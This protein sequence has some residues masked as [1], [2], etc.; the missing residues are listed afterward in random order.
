MNLFRT[1]FYALCFIVPA[2]LLTLVPLPFGEDL[3]DWMARFSIVLAMLSGMFV[4]ARRVADKPW[5]EGSGVALGLTLFGT[6]TFMT[7]LLHRSAVVIAEKML[8][9]DSV[10]AGVF[11]SVIAFIF[12]IIIR[13]AVHAC[14]HGRTSIKVGLMLELRESRKTIVPFVLSL[15][16]A[17]LPSLYYFLQNFGVHVSFAIAQLVAWVTLLFAW[18]YFSP[19]LQEVASYEL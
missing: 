15:V 14:Q 1:I 9:S 3:P 2:A 12:F 16:C 18:K 4:A 6:L 11:T 7:Y 8:L 13:V 5:D 19:F 17:A 10:L